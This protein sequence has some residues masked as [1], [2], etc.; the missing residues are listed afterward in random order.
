M[1]NR[2]LNN[3]RK[4]YMIIVKFSWEIFTQVPWV[5][6]TNFGVNKKKMVHKNNIPPLM[7]VHHIKNVVNVGRSITGLPY[8]KIF[9]RDN[10]GIISNK[11]L[12]KSVGRKKII[13]KK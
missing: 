8:L 7:I 4:T 2:I 6:Y 1:R 3:P 13:S 10:R 11:I 5:R 9:D 12:T